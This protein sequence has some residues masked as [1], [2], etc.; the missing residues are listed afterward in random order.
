M[1]QFLRRLDNLQRAI[2]SKDCPGCARPIE[3]ETDADF[4][5]QWSAPCPV[6]KRQRTFVDLAALA[7]EEG[8]GNENSAP[9][10]AA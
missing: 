7:F 1:N 6:C 3:A 5:R 2:D 9:V 10:G 8:G 4:I